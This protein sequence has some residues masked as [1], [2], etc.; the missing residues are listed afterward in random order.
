MDI[1]LHAAP[2]LKMLTSYTDPNVDLSP[3]YTLVKTFSSMTF[4]M[5]ATIFAI[6]P[7]NL[8]TSLVRIL[9]YLNV[10]R[11]RTQNPLSVFRF[12]QKYIKAEKHSK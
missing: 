5:T 11:K 12:S 2:E 4:S 9:G 7:R 1:Y 6:S 8:Y 3:L 10:P